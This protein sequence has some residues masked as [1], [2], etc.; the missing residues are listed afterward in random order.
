MTFKDQLF[1]GTFEQSKKIVSKSILTEEG[2][3]I[4]VFSSM[5]LWKR[6]TGLMMLPLFAISYGVGV[7]LPEH[8][9][10]ST[11]GVQAI[12]LAAIEIIARLGQFS[13]YFIICFICMSVGL[14]IS[15]ILPKP[16]YAYQLLYGNATL[17]I[18]SI[19]TIISAFPLTAGLTIAAFGWIGFLLQ[20]L[21]CL[22]LW[23]V[24]VMDKCQQLRTAIYQESTI[25]LD[26]GSKLVSFIK[27][28]GGILLG[29]SILNRWTLNLGELVKESPGLLSFLYGWI[30][31]LFMFLMLFA[32]GQAL[33]NTIIAYYFFRYQKEYRKHFNI[34]DEQWYGKRRSK[35]L[36]K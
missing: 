15:N 10:Q 20:L 6:I 11:E 19:T 24:C 14:I 28:Y 9:Q 23:K 13:R 31:L 3:Q 26:W 1:S 4:G 22:Y 29:L 36:S 7:V 33:K 18:L 17:I 35:I 12:S 30:F 5:S 34:S 21:L 8:F 25:A 27:S 16:N 2:A 32:L